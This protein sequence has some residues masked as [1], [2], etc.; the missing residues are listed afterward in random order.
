MQVWFS[1]Y[2]R[3]TSITELNS[4]IGPVTME[5]DVTLTISAFVAFISS[6]LIELSE[7]SEG[8]ADSPR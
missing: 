8:D 2:S 7:N 6:R 1:K 3:Q 5:R 4:R